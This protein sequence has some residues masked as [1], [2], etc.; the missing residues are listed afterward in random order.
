M[1]RPPPSS[2]REFVTGQ[3]IV[4]A[5][6]RAAE[7]VDNRWAAAA[8]ES[9]SYLLQIA[10]QA[11]ACDFQIYLN[12]GEKDDAAEHA[13]EALRILEPLEQQLS[14]YRATS[15][16]SRINQRAAE[17]P[18]VVEP[19][20][21]ALL[22]HALQLGRL[23]DG[24]FDITSGPLSKVW[25]FFRREGRLPNELEREEARALVGWDKLR[26]HD[27]TRSL[28]FERPGMEINLN[29]IGK[30]YA[31]DRCALELE[32]AGADNF[33]LHGGHSSVLARGRRTGRN[34]WAVALR[35]PLRP[36]WPLGEILL[37]DQALGTSGSANQFFHYQGQRFSHVLDPRSGWPAQQL[38]SAT[39][40]APT[41]A[42]ADA[43]STAFF[44]L[45]VEATRVICQQHT[46]LAAILIAPGPREGSLL[47]SNF[48]VPSDQ[49]QLN[50]QWQAE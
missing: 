21:Y 13:V 25:G 22:Q 7:A 32:L 23:T 9:R 15:E 24:A 48:G 19:R 10:R 34:G 4:R 11:M 1:N 37:R 38:L 49:W 17:E 39:V 40:L 26:F 46:D 3:A 27:A 47:F 8:P 30:G 41:A 20:L 44:V 16:I 43:L 50:A 2:R 31:L 6:Q 45:G 5:W 29:A 18:V 28:G 36:E 12:A 42:D 14:V 35:H 33:L